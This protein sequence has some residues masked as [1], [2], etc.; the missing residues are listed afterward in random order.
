MRRKAIHKTFYSLMIS[1]DFEQ[2]YFLSI[3]F[4]NNM[5]ITKERID[6][7]KHIPLKISNTGSLII[8][9]SVI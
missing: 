3:F 1:K 9:T 5:L 4:K 8:G 7:I 6:I 2:N